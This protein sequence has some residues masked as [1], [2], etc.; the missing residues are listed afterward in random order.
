MLW[1]HFCSIENTWNL[2]FL[3]TSVP[4][5]RR[6]ELRFMLDQRCETFS[7]SHHHLPNPWG[8]SIQISSVPSKLLMMWMRQ[9][10]TSIH[11]AQVIRTASSVKTVMHSELRAFLSVSVSLF[12]SWQAMMSRSGYGSSSSHI[13]LS[14][15]LFDST[16]VRL[17]IFFHRLT[18]ILNA[19]PFSSSTRRLTSRYTVL[20]L[21]SSLLLMLVFLY[22]YL[23][24]NRWIDWK[25]L[26][27]CG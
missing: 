8:R 1:K 6:K 10:I 25:I 17:L 19:F 3:P 18:H 23:F 9:S 12:Y 14:P 16:C 11:T 20:I 2:G 24:R 26:E 22:C 5:W 4:F 13:S 7:L 21:P 27:E 15:S